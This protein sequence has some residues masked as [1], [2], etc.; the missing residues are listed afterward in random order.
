MAPFP[1][2]I[3]VMKRNI[4]A[5]RPTKDKMDKNATILEAWI[6]G[7]QLGSLIILML[8]VICNSMELS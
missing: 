3:P 1:T 2:F 8:I 4:P 5:T 7:V 6:E